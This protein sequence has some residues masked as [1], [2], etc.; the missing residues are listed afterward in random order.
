MSMLVLDP[1]DQ[2]LI[3][4]ARAQSG[5]DR[6]DEVWEGVYMMSPLADNEHQELQTKLVAAFT[7]HWAGFTIQDLRRG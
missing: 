7:T 3:L 5:G 6:F 4:A 1:R 2:R